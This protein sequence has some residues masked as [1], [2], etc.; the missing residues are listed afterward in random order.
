MKL[1]ILADGTSL[2]PHC[3]FQ[4]N[5]IEQMFYVCNMIHCGLENLVLL[6]DCWIDHI[7]C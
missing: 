3:T 5:N 1:I 4:I 2:D 6:G 7:A